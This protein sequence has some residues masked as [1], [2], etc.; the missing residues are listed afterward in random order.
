[1]GQGLTHAHV[2]E[3]RPVQVDVHEQPW[4]E[5]VIA[6][7]FQLQRRQLREPLRILERHRVERRVLRLAFL[8]RR[9]PCAGVRNDLE[10]DLV[11][12]RLALVPVVGIALQ[13]DV[14]ALV[15]FLEHKGPGAHRLVVVGVVKDVGALIQMLGQHLRAV[16]VE[17]AEHGQRR[18][19]EAQHHSQRIRRI[20]LGHLAEQDLV[21]RVELL[22]DIFQRPFDIGR[23]E[24]LA[25][26][27]LDVGTQ[28][29]SQRLR[30]PGDLPAFS[31]GRLEL[32][33]VVVLQ[34]AV[35]HIGAEEAGRCR[36]VQRGGEDDG[37]GLDDRGQ[38]APRT[39]GFGGRGSGRG[40]R[41]KQTQGQYDGSKPGRRS[42][43]PG[44]ACGPERPEQFHHGGRNSGSHRALAARWRR[45]V[46]HREPHYMKG[47]A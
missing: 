25:V 26:V 6:A 40:A 37:L 44:G 24:R 33:V 27:P 13:H 47:A 11:Q 10:D 23:G 34:Q 21:A 9:S 3:V 43:R 39:R 42:Q 28:V 8:Q 12:V 22:P 14:V 5:P 45:S 2:L 18:L 16:A 4:R 7:R 19:G 35:E 46:K 36:R 41:A 29:E 30:I 31:Q 20:D 17:R 32:E 15:P 38:R 1:M